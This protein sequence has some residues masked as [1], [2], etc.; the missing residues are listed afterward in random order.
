MA[1]ALCRYW[2]FLAADGVTDDV[3]SESISYNLS[4]NGT[5][6][7]CNARDVLF[8]KAYLI[9]VNGIVALNLPLLLLMI[10]HSAQGSITNVKARRYVAPLLYLKWVKHWTFAPV[11]LHYRSFHCQNLSGAAR[12]RRKRDGNDVD[13]LQHHSL[14]QHRWFLRQHKHRRWE[15]EN[16]LGNRLKSILG[17]WRS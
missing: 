2:T 11:T 4:Q 7:A 1:I 8:V 13:V 12:N 6:I 15:Q 17:W 14:P 3:V 10:Y 16:W 9:G 5:P